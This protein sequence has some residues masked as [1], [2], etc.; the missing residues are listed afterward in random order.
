MDDVLVAVV[1]F[2][3]II[4][5]DA[6]VRWAVRSSKDDA[7]FKPASIMA[8]IT[9]SLTQGP[10]QFS[11]KALVIKELL[12]S[13]LMFFVL[14]VGIYFLLRVGA[15]IDANILHFG[16]LLSPFFIMPFY[17]VLY[18]LLLAHPLY[19]DDILANFHKRGVLSLILSANLVFILMD[20]VQNIVSLVGH[21]MLTFLGFVGSFYFCTKHRKKI[22]T[23]DLGAVSQLDYLEPSTV[24]YLVAILEL[25]YYLILIYLFFAKGLVLSMFPI[26]P[27][28]L[29]FSLF[30]GLLLL[31]SAAVVKYRFYERSPLTAEF[32]EERVLPLSF[33]LF[34]IMTIF[35]AYF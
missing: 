26:T 28:L 14:L 29:T 3:G 25:F 11:D 6:C 30:C 17:H 5:I 12:L 20:P 19:I 2:L 32:Y 15:P 31:L 33:L 27:G 22:S 23:F 16:L 4:I 34:A 7:Y 8:L 24:R 35:R 18:E 1:V 21:F 9:I 10:A 13:M